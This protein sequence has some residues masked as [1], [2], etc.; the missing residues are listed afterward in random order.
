MLSFG[1][2]K[3]EDDIYRPIFFID[4]IAFEIYDEVKEGPLD[5]VIWLAAVT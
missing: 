4:S 1:F 2:G 3:T 5:Y